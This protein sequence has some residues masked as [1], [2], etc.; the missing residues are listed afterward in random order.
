MLRSIQKAFD[1]IKQQDPETCITIHTIRVWCKENKIKNLR[2]G[3]KI[4]VDV[5]SLLNYI[6]NKD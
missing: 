1:I 3:T 4:L 5:E 2:A 6:S